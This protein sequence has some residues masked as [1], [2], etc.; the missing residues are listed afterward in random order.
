V[1]PVTQGMNRLSKSKEAT[2]IGGLFL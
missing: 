1:K 2:A